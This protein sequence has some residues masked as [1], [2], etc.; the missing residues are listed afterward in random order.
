MIS[1]HIL[2]SI[3]V[4]LI[5][6]SISAVFYLLYKD[7][8]SGKQSEENIFKIPDDEPMVSG[9]KEPT[10]D[11]VSKMMKGNNIDITTLKGQTDLYGM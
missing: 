5:V 2:L 4:A 7:D 11:L 9:V 8:D 10:Q 3:C 6:V 1:D